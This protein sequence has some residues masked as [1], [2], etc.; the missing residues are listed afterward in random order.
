MDQYAIHHD[1]NFVCCHCLKL[2]YKSSPFLS[3]MPG[4]IRSNKYFKMSLVPH[5]TSE[6]EMHLPSSDQLLS[7]I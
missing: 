5:L 6:N 1:I 3:N 7:H 4:N 2:E